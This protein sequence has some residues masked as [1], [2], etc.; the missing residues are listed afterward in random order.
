MREL[1]RV[2]IASVV[3]VLLTVLEWGDAAGLRESVRHALGDAPTRDGVLQG[4]AGER[5]ITVLNSC[6][7]SV[8]VGM[9]GGMIPGLAEAGCSKTNLYWDAAKSACFF[10]ATQPMKD[11]AQGDSL[12]FTL[13][14]SN[15]VTWTDPKTG[16]VLKSDLSGGIWGAT[17]CGNGGVDG[18]GGSCDTAVCYSGGETAAQQGHCA[19][20]VGPG[21]PVTKAEF[22]MQPYATDFYDVTSLDG[23]NLPV[24]MGV[25]PISQ[26]P[27]LLDAAMAPFWCSTAGG[28]SPQALLGASSWAYDIPASLRGSVVQVAYKSPPAANAACSTDADCTSP[29]EICGFVAVMSDGS[30]ALKA[31]GFTNVIAAN[32]C[33][34]MLTVSTFNGL[35]KLGPSV[36]AGAFPMGDA[37]VGCSTVVRGYSKGDWYGCGGGLLSGYDGNAVNGDACGCATTATWAKLNVTA[38]VLPGD[39]CVAASTTWTDEVFPDLVPF[40]T[41]APTTYVYPFDDKSS[42]MQCSNSHTYNSQSYV[43][44]FCPNAKPISLMP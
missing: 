9:T 21:G 20:S 6:A 36:P 15:V 35:C 42:T 24:S 5:S 40:K 14:S 34:R 27:P 22:T 4:P 1:M 38:P 29:G 43:I 44:T 31:R 8:R 19:P 32:R 33:G 11:L 28:V 39:E 23:V 10:Q 12:V 37:V 41:A 2:S 16:K 30:G 26:P 18:N 17:G 13:N 25:A 7:E 3:A